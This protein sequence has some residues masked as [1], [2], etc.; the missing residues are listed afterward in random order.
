MADDVAPVGRAEIGE[1]K[2]FERRW[3]VVQSTAWGALT[4]FVIAG[5]AGVFGSGPLSRISTRSSSGLAQ[6]EYERFARFETAAELT[7]RIDP[8]AQ[9]EGQS[10]VLVSGALL[11][12][13]R[14]EQTSPRPTW[15][16]ASP[17]SELFAFA[18]A[19]AARG[20]SI[21][22]HEEPRHSGYFSSRLEIGNGGGSVRVA[23][24]VYP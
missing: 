5:L 24:L 12:A 9:A 16:R 18:A 10:T 3:R 8:R 15:V 7:V 14:I 1:D 19:D 21:R 11:D 4:A 13:L 20:I 22:L 17:G 23:Q 6:V 2:L